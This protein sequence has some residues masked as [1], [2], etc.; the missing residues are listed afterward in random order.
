M[1]C[2]EDAGAVVITQRGAV[3][4]DF[5]NT[6][7]RVRGVFVRMA[8]AMRAG[9]MYVTKIYSRHQFGA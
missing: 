3:F 1:I 8:A 2:Y 5:F 4:L 6:P 7:G 9:F